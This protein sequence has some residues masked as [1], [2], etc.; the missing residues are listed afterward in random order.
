[1]KNRW[2]QIYTVKDGLIIKMEEFAASAA[3]ESYGGNSG[4][5]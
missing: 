1:M 5:L 4:G 2:V 3:P